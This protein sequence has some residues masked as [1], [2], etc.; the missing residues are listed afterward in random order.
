MEQ[1]KIVQFVYFETLLDSNQF[2]PKW[3]N[4]L[5]SANSDVHVT[6]QESKK[7]NLFTYIAEHRCNEDE[8]QFIFTKGARLTRL[9]EVEIK[10]RQLGGYSIVQEQKTGEA[11]ASE[12]KVFVFLNYADTDLQSYKQIQ[13]SGKLNIYKAYFE[14]SAYAYILEYFIKDKYVSAF[15]HSLH[16]FNTGEFS[17]YKQC[18]L[19]MA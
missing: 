6:M 17:I 12:S 10:T 2:M 19:K 7:N 1:G 14:N 4:Y 13:P 16:Q 18:L 3:E 8:F 9:K 11:N 5:R 15:Q